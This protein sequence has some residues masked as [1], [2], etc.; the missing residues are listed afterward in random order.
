LFDDGA[1]VAAMCSSIF[2]KIKHR[3]HNWS[4]SSRKLHMANGKI[5]NAEAKWSGTIDINGI[6]AEGNFEVFDSGGGWAFLFVKPLLQSFQANHD[7]K[8]DSITISNSSQSA[9][10]QN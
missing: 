6:Q 4:L 9:T 7:Y 2:H 1:M 3:L 10:L 8:T 5:I